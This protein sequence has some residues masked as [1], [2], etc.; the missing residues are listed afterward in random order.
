MKP[1]TRQDSPFKRDI[2]NMSMNDEDGLNAHDNGS[3][4]EENIENRSLNEE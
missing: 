3:N 4:S 2:H 1:R